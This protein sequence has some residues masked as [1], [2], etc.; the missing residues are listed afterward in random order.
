MTLLKSFL[1][2]RRG[3]VALTFAIA[4]IPLAGVSG[5]AVDYSRAVQTRHKLEIAT[6]AAA[7]SATALETSSSED[8]NAA[9]ERMVKT[10]LPADLPVSV[11]VASTSDGITTTVDVSATT[12]VKTSLLQVLQIPSVAVSA[13]S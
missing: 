10:N 13:H 2:D 4:A 5:A 6:D 8:R 7:L 9:A 3:T 12:S 1:R 11:V